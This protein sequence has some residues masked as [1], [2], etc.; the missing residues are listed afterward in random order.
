ME[1]TIISAWVPVSKQ[2]QDMQVP[3]EA[4]T[5]LLLLEEIGGTLLLEEETE[6]E[7]L[8]ELAAT[9][10][11]TLDELAAETDETLD[12]LTTGTDE[13]LDE[14]AAG[15]DEAEL[16]PELELATPVELLLLLEVGQYGRLEQMDV[17][18]LMVRLGADR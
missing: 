18:L 16:P 8:V 7:T 6:L 13:T 4:A 14:L 10:E 11:E 5:A 17:L 2:L 9:V 12:E 15:I 3:D 1:P